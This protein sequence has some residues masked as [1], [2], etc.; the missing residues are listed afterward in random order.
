MPAGASSRASGRGCAPTNGPRFSS[1]IRSTFGGL[2][3]VT[4]A[5]PATNVETSSA[6]SAVLNRRSKPIV[7]D[8]FELIPLPQSDPATW[9]GYVSTPSSSSSSRRSEWNRSSAPSRASTAR[10]GRATSPTK[11]ESPVS[12]SQGSSAREPSTTEI[13]QCSGRWP[14]VW[15]QRRTT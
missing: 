1:T 15:M 8:P 13:A 11:S 3:A 9:P 4:A 10:S 14:G 6:A 12:T 5:E 2:G 7:V